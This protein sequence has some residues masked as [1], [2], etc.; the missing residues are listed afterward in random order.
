METKKSLIVI[1]EAKAN[2]EVAESYKKGGVTGPE[3]MLKYYGKGLLHTSQVYPFFG[4]DRLWEANKDVLKEISPVRCLPFIIYSC[5][6]LCE[7]LIAEDGKSYVIDSSDG[8]V[9]KVEIPKKFLTD[10][11]MSKPDIIF[12][13]SQGITI[14]PNGNNCYIYSINE[15]NDMQFG[16][17]PGNGNSRTDYHPILFGKDI[18][19]FGVN[20][21]TSYEELHVNVKVGLVSVGNDGYNDFSNFYGVWNGVWVP[22]RSD[23]CLGC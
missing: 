5:R 21:R 16:I 6:P 17:I 23:R 15:V 20:L 10:E 13:V 11:I 2:I 1:T 18:E 3:T 22:S 14:T 7:T 12:T 19:V 9:Q 4:R 8:F